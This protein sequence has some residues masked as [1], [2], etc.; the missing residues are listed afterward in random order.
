VHAEGGFGR[1]VGQ[2][3]VTAER[4]EAP[5]E[6]GESAYVVFQLQTEF[7]Q[8]PGDEVGRYSSGVLR[9][10][11]A[12]AGSGAVTVVGTLEGERAK[13]APFA[14]G[15]RIERIVRAHGFSRRGS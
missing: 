11:G 3:V 4:S 6:I 13:P 2:G 1:I 10:G 15:H 14:P 8:S 12:V 5:A 7:A 9:P